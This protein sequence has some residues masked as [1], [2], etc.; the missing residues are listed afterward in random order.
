MLLHLL[1]P[2]RTS[3]FR[4]GTR[5]QSPGLC[6]EPFKSW[7]L[8]K[9]T[10]RGEGASQAVTGADDAVGRAAA[11]ELPQRVRQ[12]QVG[13]AVVDDGRKLLQEAC[14]KQPIWS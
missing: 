14:E 13:A 4:G 1:L 3:S 6:R 2:T 10:E 12:V 11:R 7:K 8:P 9:R 5:Q